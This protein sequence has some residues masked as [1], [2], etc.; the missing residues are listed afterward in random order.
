M[1]G[2]IPL[3]KILQYR[4]ALKDP[5]SLPIRKR[6]R[7]GGD[8]AIGVDLEEPRLLLL[9]LAER[10]LG[11]LVLEAE[12]LEHHGDF[13]AIGGLGRVEVDGGGGLGWVGGGG[14]GGDG[15][16]G[17]SGGGELEF[18]GGVMLWGGSFGEVGC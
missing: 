4:P 18:G 14:H 15:A 8:A 16:G 13:D 10:E 2:I 7:D 11:D 12:L 5:D 6:V 3:D 1:L 17:G 9:V